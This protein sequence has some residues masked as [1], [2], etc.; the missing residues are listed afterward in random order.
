[1]CSL[2][3]GVYTTNSACTLVCSEHLDL[4]TIMRVLLFALC[5]LYIFYFFFFLNYHRSLDVSV[6]S[7]LTGVI[8][9][10]EIK[11]GLIFLKRH[12]R[13]YVAWGVFMCL[14]KVVVVL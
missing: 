2:I 11:F 8:Y 10:L 9:G 3:I 14:C 7:L 12:S 6:I 1:M 13:L 4:K 5:A